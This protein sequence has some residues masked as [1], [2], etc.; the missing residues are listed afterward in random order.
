MKGEYLQYFREDLYCYCMQENQMYT[1]TVTVVTV[2]I[3]QNW[4]RQLFCDEKKTK[5][6]EEIFIFKDFC[7]INLMKKNYKTNKECKKNCNEKKNCDEKI[8][9]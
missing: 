1:V 8:A 9:D 2:V 7:K 4:W 3:K 6:E 5:Y